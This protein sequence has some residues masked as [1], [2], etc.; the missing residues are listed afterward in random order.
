M[1]AAAGAPR[2]AAGG[3]GGL[4]QSALAKALDEVDQNG[5]QAGEVGEGFM[6]HDGLARRRASSGA[7]RGALGGDALALD[8][9]DGLIRFIAAL[10]AVAFDERA[11]RSLREAEAGSKHNNNEL[12]TTP[13]PHHTRVTIGYL[14]GKLA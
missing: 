7:T 4:R 10:C 8:E 2:W 12:E 13:N 9:Q 1:G 14:S 3:G 6:D 5:G 11:G